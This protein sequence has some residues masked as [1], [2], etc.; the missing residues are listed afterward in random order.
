MAGPHRGMFRALRGAHIHTIGQNACPQA[1]TDMH[2][3][4]QRGGPAIAP[5]LG[6]RQHIGAQIGAAPAMFGRNADAK[7]IMRLQ[8]GVILGREARLAV[9]LGGARG[10]F[11]LRQLPRL[12]AERG[13]EFGQVPAVRGEN[14]RINR[15]SVKS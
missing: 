15:L 7:K 8:I 1:G 12:G 10:E 5:D 9:Y 11:R 6:R 4:G 14:R 2:V 13:L 3:E